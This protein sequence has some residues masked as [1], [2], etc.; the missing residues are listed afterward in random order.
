MTDE[1]ET[2]TVTIQCQNCHFPKYYH[3]P[4]GEEVNTYLKEE[5]CEFCNCLVIK[6]FEDNKYRRKRNDGDYE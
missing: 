1:E 4:K 5:I 2:Y 6:E 3:I